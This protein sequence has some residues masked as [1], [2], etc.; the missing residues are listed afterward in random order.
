VNTVVLLLH[1][2]AGVKKCFRALT[3]QSKA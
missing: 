1:A 3:A 2:K